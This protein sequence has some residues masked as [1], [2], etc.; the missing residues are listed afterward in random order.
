MYWIALWMQWMLYL[1]RFLK[2]NGFETKSKY[3][4]EMKRNICSSLSFLLNW[5]LNV[6]CSPSAIH[7]NRSHSFSF[8]YFSFFF[9]A[10]DSIRFVSI[11]FSIAL[12]TIVIRIVKHLLL[13]LIALLQCS[14][15]WC[16]RCTFISVLLSTV[17]PFLFLSGDIGTA[18]SF[19]WYYIPFLYLFNF[20]FFSIMFYCVLPHSFKSNWRIFFLVFSWFDQVFFYSLDWPLISFLYNLDFNKFEEEKIYLF[21]CQK[22]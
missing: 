8:F 18:N 12:L 1:F 19:V 6:Q 9:F 16:L 15:K 22:F 20:S 10:F 7:P 21:A 17:V 5:M 11:L 3:K 13:D 4:N 14:F 2:T